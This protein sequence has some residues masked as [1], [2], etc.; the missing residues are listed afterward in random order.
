[1]DWC[2]NRAEGAPFLGA[3]SALV[4]LTSSSSPKEPCLC[5]H[6]PRLTPLTLSP[7]P[8]ALLHFFEAEL[9]VRP[10]PCLTVPPAPARAL[11]QAPTA[12]ASSA[13][14]TRR[15]Y[16]RYHGAETSLWWRACSWPWPSWPC[17]W[18]GLGRG[19][20]ARGWWPG[21]GCDLEAWSESG[22]R[23]AS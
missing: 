15:F 13:V 21:P 19:H 6:C 2:N 14:S 9:T 23:A 17:C 7:H 5:M 4:A 20:R 18:C 8:P 1:M 10:P 11:S 3:W 22:T 16:G 12:R